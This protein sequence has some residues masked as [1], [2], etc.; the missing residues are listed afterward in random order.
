[1]PLGPIPDPLPQYGTYV[2]NVEL[3]NT[4]NASWFS[5]NFGISPSANSSEVDATS[6]IETVIQSVVDALAGIPN[7]TLTAYKNTGFSQ[8]FTPTE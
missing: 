6:E 5:F 1:M 7:A 2:F 3:P 4:E 8:D